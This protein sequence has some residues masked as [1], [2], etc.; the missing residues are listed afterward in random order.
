[1]NDDGKESEKITDET[2]TSDR[3]TEALNDD[4]LGEEIEAV[5]QAPTSSE[6]NL[7]NKSKAVSSAREESDEVDSRA[8][9]SQLESSHE[10]AEDDEVLFSPRQASYESE[11]SALERRS[12]LARQVRRAAE[13]V[14][15]R[16]RQK[17]KAL[18]KKIQS[19]SN[20]TPTTKRRF[21]EIDE[22]FERWSRQREEVQRGNRTNFNTLSQE[23]PVKNNTEQ[24]VPEDQSSASQAPTDCVQ[25][26]VS[27]EDQSSTVLLER[28]DQSNIDPEALEERSSESQAPTPDVPVPDAD[29]T[30]WQALSDVVQSSDSQN[31]S[32]REILMTDSITNDQHV[33]ITDST[34]SESLT[35]P[36]RDKEDDRLPLAMRQIAD[37]NRRGLMESPV[38]QEQPVVNEE[39]SQWTDPAE[40]YEPS[41]LRRGTRCRKPN[42]RYANADAC[43]LKNTDNGEVSC[44]RKI[45]SCHK[46][47]LMVTYRCPELFCRDSSIE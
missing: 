33:P 25:L 9:S 26:P 5:S 17:R 30:S 24:G 19:S 4:R 42:S 1:M 15:P 47:P 11:A 36:R 34:E 39:E 12:R 23:S 40:A 31:A 2:P 45:M 7:F 3:I 8:S 21:R 6:A 16:T 28:P 38:E 18:R 10:E 37:F 27:C 43:L 14:T 41:T 46:Y 13:E 20:I 35:V 29:Q 22:R 32:E 44:L